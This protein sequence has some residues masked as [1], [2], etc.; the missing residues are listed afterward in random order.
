MKKKSV[1]QSGRA[2]CTFAISDE[3]T[4]HTTNNSNNNNNNNNNKR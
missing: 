3:E 1:W 4:L 2:G